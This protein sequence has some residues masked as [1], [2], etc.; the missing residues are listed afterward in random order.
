MHGLPI[1]PAFAE[2]RAPQRALRKRLGMDRHLPA[3]LLVGA[4]KVLARS[5]GRL[6][7]S[8]SS[9][10]CMPVCKHRIT[11]VSRT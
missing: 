2:A 8:A 1:R 10:L 5:R 3:V 9:L 6:T 11:L 4:G 7:W